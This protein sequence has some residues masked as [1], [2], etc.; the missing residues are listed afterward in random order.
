MW[1]AYESWMAVTR[2]VLAD[3]GEHHAAAS[4]H[5]KR[6]DHSDLK[7]RHFELEQAEQQGGAPSTARTARVQG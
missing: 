5:G 1:C 3:P 4:S 6:P 2:C 7:R